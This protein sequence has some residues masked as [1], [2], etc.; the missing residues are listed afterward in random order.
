[1]EKRGARVTIEAPTANAGPSGSR[2]GPIRSAS[3]RITR[4][5]SRSPYTGKLAPTAAP[6]P[7]PNVVPQPPPTLGLSSAMDDLLLSAPISSRT[8]RRM[9]AVNARAHLAAA[10]VAQPHGLPPQGSTAPAFYRARS[11]I[12]PAPQ[13]LPRRDLGVGTRARTAVGRLAPLGAAASTLPAGYLGSAYLPSGPAL[14][15]PAVDHRRPA[16]PARPGIDLR[17][18]RS[19]APHSHTS[20]T[21][22]QPTHGRGLGLLSAR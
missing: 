3:K 12:A 17:K 20:L 4:Q 2:P 15:F 9:H 19:T 7:L 8:R 6:P 16:P 22:L 5:Q 13:P 1:M 10:A 18:T 21:M 11:A 14:T